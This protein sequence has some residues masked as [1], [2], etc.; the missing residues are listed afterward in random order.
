MNGVMR[1]TYAGGSANFSAIRYDVEPTSHTPYSTSR[2]KNEYA[3]FFENEREL[4]SAMAGTFVSMSGMNTP[5]LTAKSKRDL[6]FD[7]M[8]L[9][10]TCYRELG[11]CIC[12]HRSRV[13]RRAIRRDG[14]WC[15]RF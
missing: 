3:L 12:S 15:V 14:Y 5:A 13:E 9:T 10:L 8:H 2:Q 1:T 7:S 4:I 6:S 11:G